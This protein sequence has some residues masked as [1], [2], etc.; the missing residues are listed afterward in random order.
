MSKAR[1]FDFSL[2]FVALLIAFNFNHIVVDTPIYIKA[3]LIYWIFSSLY[4]HLS[5]TSKKGKANID[6]GISYTSSFGIFA[7]PLGVLIFETL[8]RFTVYFYKKQT[9]TAD[10]GEFLDTFYNIG[11]FVI[12][13][14]IGYYL[15]ELLF[16]FFHPF[17]FG[18]WLLILL[19]ICIITSLSSL[20]L[21]IV[22][23]ILGDITS[24]RDVVDLLFRSRSILD[25]GKIT[26]TNGLLLIFLQ[27]QR[28]EMLI[29]L[30]LL[31][32]V[33]SLSFYSKSQSLQDKVERDQFE[34]MAYTDFLTNIYNRAFMD[35]KM[36]ELNDTK[37]YIGIVVA[38][39]DT[40]KKINDTY[41]HAVG[42]QVIQDFANKLKSYLAED[43][44]LFRSGGE[45]F[46]LFLR[47]RNFQE[48]V[49]LVKSIRYGIEN[50]SVK[51]E[52]NNESITISYT[53]SY[54]LFFFQANDHI[55]M[56]KAYV[57][58]DQL[59]LQSKKLGKN[60]VSVKNGLSYI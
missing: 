17:P 16:P 28:W 20:L 8:Y 38:D 13:G 36:V 5:I 6:Y 29:I 25:I 49:D 15:Y 40:F 55:T 42:D 35:K 27:E 43:D 60:R 2:L 46:T 59:L 57:Q 56:E 3:L 53:A 58:A 34:K 48:N 52:Y 21:S 33:V 37:E 14:S 9:K 54:G 26:F 12:C 22:L 39:I 32:Y 1:L 31:N 24:V 41:N 23:Y 18:Y 4:Y 30:F 44:L 47:Q 19:L 11:T 45:E 51:S 10:P 7:G 50:T